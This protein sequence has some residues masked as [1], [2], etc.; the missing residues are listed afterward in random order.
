MPVMSEQWVHVERDLDAPPEA[1]FDHLAEHENLAAL[2]GAKVT[3]L[4]DGDDGTRNGAGSRRSLKV[5][6][7]P[8]F[9][10]TTTRCER[11]SLIEY[12]ITRGG[13]LKD[14]VGIMRFSPTPS[15]GTHFDYRIRVIA[16]VPGL[17]PVIAASLTR[18]IEKGLATVPG[19]R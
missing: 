19:G 14:H 7:L 1:V 16:K 3:R 9:E 8:A 13:L 15:G 5:G 12:R 6:P 10:E 11:P 18:S 17:S 4:D 2:F